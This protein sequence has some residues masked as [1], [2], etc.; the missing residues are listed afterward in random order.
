[1]TIR[2]RRRTPLA[3]LIALSSIVATVAVALWLASGSGAAMTGAQTVGPGNAPAVTAIGSSVTLSWPASTLEPGGQPVGGYIVTRYDGSGAPQAIG[4]ACSDV[5]DGLQC[6]ETNVP[7]GT[8]HYSV[9]PVIGEWRGSESATTSVIVAAPTLTTVTPNARGQGFTGNLTLTGTNLVNGAGVVFSGTG[10]TVNTVTFN[11]PTQLTVNISVAP[12][13]TIGARN[14]TV[15]NPDG[16]TATCNNCFTVNTGPTLTTVTPNARGQGFTG[17]LTLTGTNLVNG[18]GVVFSGTGITVNTVTFNSP[19]QLTVNISVAPTATIGARNV[20]VTNPDGGTATCNNCFTVNTGPTLTTVT[21]NARGQGFT[22][23]LTLTG[24]NLVNGAGVVF[25][26]TGITVNTVTF[27]SPTQ[28]TVNISVAPTATIG[29]RNVTVT[30]PDGGTATCNNCFTVNTGPTLTTVTP[31]ARGQGFTGNLTLTGTNLVNGAGVVFSGTGITVNTVTFNSPTQL[32]VNISV[33]PTATIGARN[34]TVTNPDGGTATCNNCFTVNTGPTVS[35]INPNF[36]LP[37]NT[38]NNVVV[39]GTSFVSGATVSLGAGITVNSVTFNSPTQLTVNITVLSTAAIGAR[40]VTVTNPDGGVGACASCY[41]VTTGPTVTS[42]TPNSRG[43]AATNQDLVISG[44]FF[45]PGATVTFSGAGITV[46]TVTFNSPTQ[47]TV[48]ISILQGAAISARNVTVSNPTGFGA[49]VCTACFS[50]AARPGTFSLNPN[51]RGQGAANQVIVITGSLFQSGATVAFSG[52]GITLNSVT[53]NSATQLTVNISIAAGA[54]TGA[55]NVTITNPDGGFRTASAFT[56][57]AAPNPT[58]VNPN[59][60]PQGFS[61]TVTIAGSGFVNGATVAFSG[62]G[63]TVNSVTFNNASQ[64]TVNITIA[65][66]ATTGAR[67]VTLTNPNAGTATCVGCLTVNPRPLPTS[68]ILASRARATT[69]SH[70]IAG[71]GFVSGASVV[72]SGTGITVNT[73]TF[74]SST[75]LTINITVLPAASLGARNVTVTN[76]DMGTGTCTGCFAVS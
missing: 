21:P 4:P 30:N 51:T 28:L 63:I 12:T 29:A 20:T 52:T 34:V 54:T 25:S 43:Q 8:W 62:T 7:D 59:S 22:G 53:F 33:A 2:R 67:N 70:T 75:Q 27:N 66:D 65:A 60:R 36:G 76:P 39:T 42:V 44:T 56:V 38:Y 14:V 73:V 58:S 16:G 31:N 37:N 9:T 47:L 24:T 26:G 15:T 3:G 74:N 18:A 40:N 41:T 55:R 11:S 32:T 46:N 71:T 5:V 49:G 68:V 13:A 23:N 50:V 72:F 10:I 57:A 69:G 6:I 45:R 17:N 61:G 64:L 1:M 19:T 48:N 35:A